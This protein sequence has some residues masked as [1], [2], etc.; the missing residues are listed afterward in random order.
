VGY[1]SPWLED[2]DMGPD[3]SLHSFDGFY[4]ASWL[5]G[6][7]RVCT[8]STWPRS[9]RLCLKVAEGLELLLYLGE[10]LWG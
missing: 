2:N 5:E 10:L 3:S 8:L 1:E 7:K 6:R 4:A 9:W